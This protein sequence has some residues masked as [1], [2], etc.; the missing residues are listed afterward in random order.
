MSKGFYHDGIKEYYHLSFRA[1]TTEGTTSKLF[2]KKKNKNFSSPIVK[3]VN[4]SSLENAM[5]YAL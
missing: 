4:F 1:Y 2:M 5:K 3:F